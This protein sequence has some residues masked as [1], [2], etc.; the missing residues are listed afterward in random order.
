M[1]FAEGAHR[2]DASKSGGGYDM[3]DRDDSSSGQDGGY[4]PLGG[5]LQDSAVEA[6]LEKMLDDFFEPVENLEDMI[7]EGHFAEEKSTWETFIDALNPF[8]SKLGLDAESA[9]PTYEE[10]LAEEKRIGE[11]Y[12]DELSQ[13][14]EITRQGVAYFSAIRAK[15]S[16][17]VMM[18]TSATDTFI[19]AVGM[20]FN[21]KEAL[22]LAAGAV[23]LT[24]EQLTAVDTIETAIRAQQD[25]TVESHK[26]DD[27]PVT[28]EPTTDPTGENDTAVEEEAKKQGEDITAGEVDTSELEEAEAKWPTYSGRT[29]GWSY[30]VPGQTDYW[31]D[32]GI[33]EAE[34]LGSGDRVA[35]K[36]KR[37]K[38]RKALGAQ[39]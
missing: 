17:S 8:K 9:K 7:K 35:R 31:E 32:W 10:F 15:Q 1:A 30:Q 16:A 13:Y 34:I 39:L 14:D 23:G 36:L 22:E 33:T 25:F 20:I 5:Y 12:A 27:D 3:G 24:P 6:E 19:K 38:F 4:D 26:R 2:D 11:Q 29:G 21:R 28:G 18:S 37:G